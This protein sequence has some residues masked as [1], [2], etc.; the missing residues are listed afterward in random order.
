MHWFTKKLKWKKNHEF[1]TDHNATGVAAFH[2]NRM[3]KKHQS[4][5]E[6]LDFDFQYC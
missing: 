6:F 2:K 5:P 4:F 1:N 3:K